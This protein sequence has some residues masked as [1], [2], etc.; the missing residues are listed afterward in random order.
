MEELQSKIRQLSMRG[1]VIVVLHGAAEELQ[2][3]RQEM[4]SVSTWM[5]SYR[6][7]LHKPPSSKGSKTATAY[8]VI[9]QDTQRLFAAYQGDPQFAQSTLT[10]ACDIMGTAGPKMYNAGMLIDASLCDA[11][12]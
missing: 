3:L 7:E 6:A 9:I 10:R 2:Y 4:P 11:H 1:P 12:G 8:P 5:T